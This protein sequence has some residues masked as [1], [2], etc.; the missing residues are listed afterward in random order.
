MPTLT[1][2][3]LGGTSEASEL[4]RLIAGDRRFAPTLSLAGATAQPA[5]SPI[6]RR[7]GGFGGADGLA[8][9][10]RQSATT[11]LVDATHPFAAR[12]TAN[13]HR[14]AEAAGVRLLR[15]RRPAWTPMPGD[16]WQLVADMQ[17]ACDA[18]GPAPRRVLLT[19]GRQDLDAFRAA[20]QHWYLARSIDP[21]AEPLP[22]CEIVLARGPYDLGEELELLASRRI[23]VLVTKNSGGAATRAKLD[24][25]RTLGLPVVM[26]AR[27]EE[28]QAAPVADAHEAFAWLLAAHDADRGA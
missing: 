11:H 26:V 9:Y 5:W 14:A 6:V 4:A 27:P 7:I 10:L 25:A 22:G 1:V 12:I 24:A 20:T 23:D 16:H 21:P 8:C 18:L 19:V 17:S 28:P 2:L 3:I 13:A 15:L